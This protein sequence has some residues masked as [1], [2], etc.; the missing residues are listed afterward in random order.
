[1]RLPGWGAKSCDQSLQQP[2]DE[3]ERVLLGHHKEEQRQNEQAVDEE[4]DNDRNR[5]HP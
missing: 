2:S 5:V 1:M 3:G 4:S